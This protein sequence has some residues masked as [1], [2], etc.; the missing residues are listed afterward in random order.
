[1]GGADDTFAG[2]ALPPNRYFASAGNSAGGASGDV[3]GEGPLP[4]RDLARDLLPRD[5]GISAQY[6]AAAAADAAASAVAAECEAVSTAA[7]AV[8]A[9]P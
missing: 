7:A 5:L 1:M 9:P 2:E 4:T 3:E 6:G 8:L